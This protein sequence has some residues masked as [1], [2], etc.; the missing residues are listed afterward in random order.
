MMHD[1]LL[2]WTVG[3]TEIF[4]YIFTYLH[5][6]LRFLNSCPVHLLILFVFYLPI[7]YVCLPYD[8]FLMSSL[9]QIHPHIHF[10]LHIHP[11]TH[12]TFPFSLSAHCRSPI[13][14]FPPASRPRLHRKYPPP[15]H[16]LT[17]SPP[18]PRPSPLAPR[19]GP[20]PTRPD[21]PTHMMMQ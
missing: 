2:F 20:S 10:H 15:A 6:Y 3:I 9:T 12:P 11:T 1:A 13:S 7:V 16:P 8:V 17:R 21:P 19:P 18:S 14:C 4:L 5:P